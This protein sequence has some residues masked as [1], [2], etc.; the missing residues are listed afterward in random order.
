[1]ASLSGAS[2]ER[3]FWRRGWV[4]GQGCRFSWSV[5]FGEHGDDKLLCRP[6]TTNYL[7]RRC[8]GGRP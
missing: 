6:M 8:K 7:G 2:W 1:M 5:E 4:I 3:I